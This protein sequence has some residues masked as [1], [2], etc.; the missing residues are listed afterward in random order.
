MKTLLSCKP[1]NF[2][3]K[4]LTKKIYHQ[5]V[6]QTHEFGV[7]LCDML[8]AVIGRLLEQDSMRPG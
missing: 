1:S 4:K 3:E 5:T 8:I 6:A 2:L 7:A